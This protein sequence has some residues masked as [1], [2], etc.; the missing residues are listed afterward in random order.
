MSY[1][2]DR[3]M[4]QAL[5]YLVLVEEKTKGKL[6]LTECRNLIIS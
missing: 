6:F 2:V 4:H 1:Y 3:T 5:T